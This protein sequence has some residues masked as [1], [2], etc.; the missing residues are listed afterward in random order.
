[1]DRYVTKNGRWT[2]DRVKEEALKYKSIK[3]FKNNNRNAYFKAVY[4]KWLLDVIGH[5]TEGNTKWTIDKIVDKLSQYDKKIWY[6][7]PECKA[8]YY[9]M[10]RHDI[11]DNVM[12]KLNEKK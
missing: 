9:Y 5:M 12:T 6:K 1:M 7:T 11:T 3:D 8:A 10:K 4:S 2:F